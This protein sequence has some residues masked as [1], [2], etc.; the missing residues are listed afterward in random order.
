[1]C[2]GQLARSNIPASSIISTYLLVALDMNQISR[3]CCYRMFPLTQTPYS[4]GKVLM[5]LQYKCEQMSKLVYM[6][7]LSLKFKR[8]LLESLNPILINSNLN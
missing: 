1:M 6:I 7:N 8:F 4:V 5:I 3:V 2:A